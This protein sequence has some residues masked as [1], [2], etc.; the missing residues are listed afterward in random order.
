LSCLFGAREIRVKISIEILISHGVKNLMNT[1]IS[2][3]SLIKRRK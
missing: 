1:I 3:D 2:M